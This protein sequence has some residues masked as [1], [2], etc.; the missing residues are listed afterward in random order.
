[1]F[2]IVFEGDGEPRKYLNDINIQTNLKCMNLLI[3]P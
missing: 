2:D 3:Y 1:M